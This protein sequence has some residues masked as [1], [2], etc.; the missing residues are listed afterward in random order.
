MSF[1]EQADLLTR[2]QKLPMEKLGEIVQL[3]L[4]WVPTSYLPTWYRTQVPVPVLSIPT[5]CTGT[6]TWL[7]K[8]KQ[9]PTVG[10]GYVTK[11]GQVP[12][13]LVVDL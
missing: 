3:I 6:G 11:I 2:I 10:Y 1:E 9:V 12:T 5:G 4:V 7:L 13:Y 8:V